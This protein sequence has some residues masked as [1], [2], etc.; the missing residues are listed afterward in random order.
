MPALK[1]KLKDSPVYVGVNKNESALLDKVNQILVT[2]KS[3]GAL[4]KNAL[5]WLKEPLPADL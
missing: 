4:E 5:T 3:D 1:V 2:A